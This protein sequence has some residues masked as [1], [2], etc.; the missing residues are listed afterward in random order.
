MRLRIDAAR[1]LGT[2]P[3]AHLA[4]RDT[5]TSPLPS[6]ISEVEGVAGFSS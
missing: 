2:M 1:V 6:A 3:Y 4:F 5:L